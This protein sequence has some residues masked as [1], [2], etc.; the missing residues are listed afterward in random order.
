[1]QTDALFVTRFKSRLP[2]PDT[3]AG[4]RGRVCGQAVVGAPRR[5]RRRVFMKK[6]I[7]GPGFALRINA[8]LPRQPSPPLLHPCGA[9][10]GHPLE[11]LLSA[12]ALQNEAVHID[13][14]FL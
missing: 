12:N 7:D 11:V 8:L 1:M 14:F 5:W 9:V 4:F 3:R 10:V 2:T 13:H 6:S